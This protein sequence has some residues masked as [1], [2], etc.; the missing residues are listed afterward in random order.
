MATREWKKKGIHTLEAFMRQAEVVP[1]TRMKE[2]IRDVVFSD[3]NRTYITRLAPKTY[4][5]KCSYCGHEEVKKGAIHHGGSHMCP[6]CG[7]SAVYHNTVYSLDSK[8][9]TDYL[10]Y[11]QPIDETELMIRAFECKKAFCGNGKERI[12]LH[13]V[14]RECT[15]HDLTKRETFHQTPSGKWKR[16]GYGMRY[17]YYGYYDRDKNGIGRSFVY[18]HNL[19]E[20]KAKQ[21]WLKYSLF[22]QRAER[23]DYFNPFNY[24]KSY[25]IYPQIEYLEKIGLDG[26]ADFIAEGDTI[27]IHPSEKKLN[28]LLRLQGKPYVE[29][30]KRINPHKIED[31]E[32]IQNMEKLKIPAEKKYFEFYHRLSYYSTQALFKYVTPTGLYEY[33]VRQGKAVD[34][35]SNFLRDYL[36]YIG[37]AES[38]GVD[39]ADTM[40]S[41]PRN[42][43]ELHDRFTARKIERQEKEKR[44]KNARVYKAC[45]EKCKENQKFAYQGKTLSIVAPKSAEDMV[46][47]GTNNCNCVGTYIERVGDG[48]SIIL[49]VRKNDALNKSFCTLEISPG[50]YRVIQCRAYRNG[51]APEEVVTFLKEWSKKILQPLKAQQYDAAGENKISVLIAV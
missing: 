13:E 28:A 23:G 19:A 34:R 46:F 44:Q 38:E 37:L 15:H 26:I 35:K 20:I 6:N 18:P 9:Q 16:G 41:K 25:R 4:A 42:F 49:F 43:D 27:H 2:F 40:F 39:M 8:K 36:D 48:R 33:A 11:L 7:R 5:T 51:T 17:D 47:E 14:Q 10:Y 22:Q 45:D 1:E 29:L 50:D 12:Y 24:I 21:V 30:V 32:V 31:I 3:F